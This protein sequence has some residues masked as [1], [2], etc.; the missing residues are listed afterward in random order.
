[1]GTVIEEIRE[2]LAKYPQARIEHDTSSI[3][4]YPTD[5]EG[6]LV[7]LTV[8]CRSGG[9]RY[10]VYYNGSREDFTHRGAAVQAFGFGLSTGCRLREYLRAGRAVRW[11]VEAWSPRR[12][13]WEADWDF[14]R[15]LRALAF[16]WRRL[17][18]RHLQNRIIDL[19]DE[20]A[21]ENG[22]PTD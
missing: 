6:F 5:P 13:R 20:K 21:V 19:D 10:A 14:V 3:T 22:E 15:V 17:T 2:K 1:M 7:R 12:Q 18:V 9:E 4:W 8:E 16:S 11:I